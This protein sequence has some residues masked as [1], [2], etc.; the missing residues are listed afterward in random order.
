MLGIVG[1]KLKLDLDQSYE[2]LGYE[3][4]D[5]FGDM[6]AAFNLALEDPEQLTRRGIDKKYV[7]IMEEIAKE[8]ITKKEVK[9]KAVLEVKFF[10]GDGVSRVKEFLNSLHNKYKWKIKYISAPR[11]SIEIKT[12]DPK[13]TERNLRENLEKEISNIKDGEV[14]FEIGGD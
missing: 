7:K 4:Q 9:I 14:S 12:N 8:N 2:K 3:L 10:T 13:Q 11:Y 1:K 5:V 6:F